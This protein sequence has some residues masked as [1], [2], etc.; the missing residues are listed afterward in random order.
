MAILTY[1]PKPKNCA[2]F[3]NKM[4]KTRDHHL[5]KKGFYVQ[6]STLQD[7]GEIR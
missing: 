1:C 5:G 4:A 3:L 6:D 2:L 7:S